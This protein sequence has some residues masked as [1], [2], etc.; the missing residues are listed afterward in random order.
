MQ[1]PVA[2]CGYVC[3]CVW[4]GGGDRHNS[5]YSMAM[6]VESYGISQYFQCIIRPNQFD[7]AG[8]SPYF[9]LYAVGLLWIQ[10]FI[11]HYTRGGDLFLWIINEILKESI[12][13][14]KISYIYGENFI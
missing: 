8:F 9:P 5:I 11:A 10:G 12:F 13:F 7:L 6:S 1:R 14:K 2:Q 3:V 4:G